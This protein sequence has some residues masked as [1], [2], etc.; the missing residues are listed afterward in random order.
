[1]HHQSN[2]QANAASHIM[3]GLHKECDQA[4]AAFCITGGLHREHKQA[5]HGVW[6]PMAFNYVYDW[7]EGNDNVCSSNSSARPSQFQFHVFSM[8][9]AVPQMKR[10]HI[11]KTY[12]PNCI[13]S[14]Y[15]QAR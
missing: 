10:R 5:N 2:E 4:D 3:G 6:F 7:A 9:T 14:T 15:A 13:S 12:V 11:E 1:M 8:D